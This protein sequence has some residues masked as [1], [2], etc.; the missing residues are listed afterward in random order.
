MNIG[1]A[2][3]PDERED[4]ATVIWHN[5]FMPDEYHLAL[6]QIDQA[7][8]DLYAITEGLAVLRFGSR[9]SRNELARPT[10]L[11]MLTGVALVLGGAEVLS[12]WD[13][14]ARGERMIA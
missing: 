2:P 6:R 12:R 14:L 4:R 8:G 9:C 5:V 10:L 11:A 3:F 7:R 13:G 1:F